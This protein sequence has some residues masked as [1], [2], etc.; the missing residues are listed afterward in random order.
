MYRAIIFLICFFT[1][2]MCFAEEPRNGYLT[3][4]IKENAQ[5][6]I[7]RI[8]R[9]K[10][11]TLRTEAEEPTGK[12]AVHIIRHPKIWNKLTQAEK[13]ALVDTPPAE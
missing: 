9:G 8:K 5:A 13:K 12:Y 7:D 2:S 11:I 3:Y 1:V 10:V 6:V 4:V